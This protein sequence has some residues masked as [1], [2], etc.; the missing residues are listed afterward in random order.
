LELRLFT[1]DDFTDQFIPAFSVREAASFGPA[2]SLPAQVSRCDLAQL[3]VGQIGQAR[4][5][6][7]FA[8]PVGA[9]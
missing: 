7:R 8:I 4:F 2:R 3:A 6:L 1:L 5:G 9:E